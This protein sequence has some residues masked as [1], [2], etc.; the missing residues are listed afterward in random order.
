MQSE[1]SEKSR[2]GWSRQR[3]EVLKSE[4]GRVQYKERRGA[5]EMGGGKGSGEGGGS[6]DPPPQPTT[7]MRFP[8]FLDLP[9]GKGCRIGLL[10]MSGEEAPIGPLWDFGFDIFS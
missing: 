10:G 3:G 8:T 2:S 7:T 9:K 4:E 5:D 6:G 1:D